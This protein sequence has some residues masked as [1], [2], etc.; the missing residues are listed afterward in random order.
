MNKPIL[1]PV[2][3]DVVTRGSAARFAQGLCRRRAVPRSG[4]VGRRGA[5]PALRHIR[6][7]YGRCAEDR[8]R[9]GLGVAARDWILARG[10][11]EEYDGRARQPRGRRVEARRAA[12]GAAI[13][14]RR[15]C[16]PLRAKPGRHVTQLHYA[17]A[18]LI[19]EEMKF[20]AAR[21]NLGRSALRDGNSFGAAIPDRDHARIRA[22]RNGP[23]PRHHSRPTSTIPKPSR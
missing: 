16:K 19:T 12:V 14:P 1:N 7:V 13:R 22:R 11:V 2:T 20:I 6:S 15:A 17:R 21:E 4:A 10:D 8:H 5:G 18:G 3:N 23:R 9:K